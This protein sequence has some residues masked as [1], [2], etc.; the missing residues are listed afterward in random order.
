M[1]KNM[2]IDSLKDLASYSQLIQ[3]IEDRISPI[4]VHGLSE[5]NISHI[6]YGINQ[7]LDKQILII[8]YDELRAKKISED[9]R[10]FSKNNTE[11]FPTRE[12]I[13]YN[14][15]AYSHDISNQ[16]L[17]VLDR[18]SNEENIVVVASIH[19][20]VN[21][22][23]NSSIIK[24]Y[25]INLNFGD[26]IELSKLTKVFVTQGYERVDIVEG[27]G[28]FS[29]RGG[30]IDF[31]PINTDNPYRIE[32]F[33]DEI[34]SIRKFDLKTQR[35]IENIERISIPPA[36]EVLIEDTYISEV[37]DNIKSDLNSSLKK[38][39]RKKSIEEVKENLSQKFNSYIEKISNRVNIE[40]LD[41]I[42]PYIPDNSSSIIDYLK[43]D[44]IILVDEPQKIELSVKEIKQS[45]TTKYTDL[46]E[47]G[48]VL[49]RQQEIYHNYDD[50]IDKIN[51]R[52][53]LTVT[54][55]LKNDSIFKPKSILNFTVK[56]MQSFHNKIDILIDDLKFYKTRGYKVI[57]LSG[58]EERGRRLVNELLDKGVDCVFAEDSDKEIHPGQVVITS[59]SISKGFEYSSLKFAI[60]SDKEVFGTYKKKKVNKKRKDAVKITSF[61]DLKIGD[62]V[63][64]ES[65]GIG[66][67][68]GIDQLNVQGVKK[69]YIAVK[70]SGEDRLYVPVDQ[71]NLIQKYIGADSVEPKVNKL[72][73]GDWAKTKTKVKKAIE[74][75]AKDLIKLYATRE[76]VKGYKF[77]P[78]TPW[79]KQFEEAFIYEETE[80]QLRCI[81]EIKVDMEKERP[82][83][84]LLCGDVGYGKT[85]VAVR[86][87]FKAVMD[88]KQVAFLVPTTILA[89]QHFNTLVERF[90]N[91][92]VKI[93][94]L[95]RFRT[96]G[97]Q[98]KIL[99]DLKSGNLDII[100]GTHRLL[101]K[102]V[103]FSDLGLLIV[104]EEQRFGVKHK[105]AIKIL[106]ESI[107]VLTLTATP[108]PRTL[109]MS[110]IG[111][112]DMS[113]LEEP[114][115]ERY[116]I[117]TYVVEHN[118]QIVR[119]A[120][121]KEL[122]R[123]GQIYILY[124]KVQ[125][126]DQFASKI[127]N[128]V[129]E[130]R[131]VVGHGQMSERELERVM[132]D[133]LDG[134]YDVLVCTTIIETGLDIPNVNTIIIH[135]SDKMGL[136]QLY[137]L[138]GRVGRS[139][140]VAFAYFMY[141]R[142]KVLTEVAEKRLK[143]IKE[144]TEFGSG[145]KIAMR[146][147][148]I[149][150]SGNLLGAEQH[151]QMS[152]IGY[153]LYVK[154][155]D[156][157]IRKLKGEERVEQIDTTIELNVDGYIPDRYIKNEDHKIEMYKKISA[158]EN[159][160]DYSD[161][162]EEIIDRFG[163]VPNQVTNLLKISYIKSLCNKARISH[164]TQSEYIVK[165][166][167]NEYRDMTPELVNELS[168]RFG[169]RVEFDISKTP[170]I[171]YKLMKQK[172]SDIL[173]ELED[174]IGKI[175][176]FQSYVSKL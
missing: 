127:Q 23:V 109:H 164:V 57:L 32:L 156:E 74:D 65:H 2:F 39:Q 117:Q 28:Q 120:I 3:N 87:A 137:Q 118:E 33:D 148:E 147:L 174:V 89:Q 62:Y 155:L 152:A 40:N 128:L 36:K 48:E 35:S 153:D 107:D 88:G 169:R 131:V 100:V 58:V 144:F 85:E 6:S 15:D 104:D 123:N 50:I 38:L 176:S 53:C 54:N 26:T 112:R 72:S 64:H 170:Y 175:S 68:V 90:A 4:S 159:K 37:V 132:F 138:R 77:S 141:E 51:N 139:N 31:F 8:T 27:K 114:P 83:D 61:T 47:R 73:S 66:K 16:R 125:S 42:L 142:N 1:S 160:S 99:N 18:L 21:R 134:E 116:P 171:K 126:I 71:M 129:P 162:L 105:E 151:V 154:Y 122:N 11:L 22:I 165:L 75:M 76:T 63:V 46:F 84:R 91:F 103:K 108:I 14:I 130:S 12:I 41:L 172:Q 95:S 98:K 94:M 119:D 69:D 67:Y 82:M 97:Q 86:A 25:T 55:L 158:I 60:I 93:E 136:S 17:K 34:D 29:I 163:D 111:I 92:P 7:H 20:I 173:E 110:L 168:Q 24:K 81:E 115:E 79:Q 80:D 166:V 70:Y 145:F 5:E 135:D 146:D 102:D 150:G 59:G 157:A 113:I 96:P 13:F 161:I 106:K 78:D 167:F 10:L 121:I 43:K 44:S 19:G 56:S 149:R 101:S 49:V 52:V 133:F 140:R 143:A 9:L 124:N 45:F 30:I